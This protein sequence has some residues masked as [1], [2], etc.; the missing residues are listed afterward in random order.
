[1]SRRWIGRAVA[2]L[3]CTAV[4]TGCAGSG[5]GASD[6]DGPTTS[7]E[8][9][10]GTVA[11]LEAALSAAGPGSVITIADGTYQ[12]DGGDRWLAAADGTSSE[13]I[14]LRGGRDAILES[15]SPDGDYG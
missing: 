9:V 13:P 11:Q 10:I 5:K 15:D 1:M 12:R 7:A 3:L 6:S 8:T 4:L 14:T 2:V